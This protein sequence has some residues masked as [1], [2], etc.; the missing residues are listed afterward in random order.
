M[1]DMAKTKRKVHWRGEDSKLKHAVREVDGVHQDR[2]VCG[3]KPNDSWSPPGTR[4]KPKDLRCGKCAAW[5]P[6]GMGP[7][8]ENYKPKATVTT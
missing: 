2:A 6:R 7:G 1:E 4:S 5:E 3:A 8:G